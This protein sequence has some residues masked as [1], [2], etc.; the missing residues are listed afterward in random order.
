VVDDAHLRHSHR[1]GEAVPMGFQFAQPAAQEG[2]PHRV[3][4]VGEGI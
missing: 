4:E 3:A 1:D 2:M